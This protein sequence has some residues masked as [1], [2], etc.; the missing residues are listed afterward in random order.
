MSSMPGIDLD[1][2]FTIVF[3]FFLTVL[4]NAGGPFLSRGESTPGG[5][6]GMHVVSHAFRDQG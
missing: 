3:T 2:T 1:V 5:R 4:A 6:E